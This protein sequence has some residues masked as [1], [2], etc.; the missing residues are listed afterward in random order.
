MLSGFLVNLNIDRRGKI[1]I[2]LAKKIERENFMLHSSMEELR[3]LLNIYILETGIKA[4]YIANKTK[5]NECVLSRF[6]HGTRDLYNN[7][8]EDLKNFLENSKQGL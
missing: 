2:N 1:E 7:H 4:K 3:K 8:F 5:I 6:R